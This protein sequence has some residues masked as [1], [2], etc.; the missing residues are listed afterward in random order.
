MFFITFIRH[1]ALF[2][3]A[4][5]EE[6]EVNESLSTFHAT[7]WSPQSYHKNNKRSSLSRKRNSNFAAPKSPLLQKAE[8]LITTVKSQ[9]RT[10]YADFFSSFDLALLQELLL[11]LLLVL[12]SL[13][14]F[15][16]CRLL[17]LVEL[18][19]LVFC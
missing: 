10:T 19:R 5:T 9:K 3:R 14:N 2:G 6:R 17:L 16:L 13:E 15:S 1:D 7:I 4:L 11:Q 8:P 12:L 18:Q